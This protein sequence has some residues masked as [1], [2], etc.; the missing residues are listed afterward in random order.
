MLTFPLFKPNQSNTG[1]A[2]SFQ[3]GKTNKGD[4]LF[5]SMVR[6]KSWSAEKRLGSFYSN[7]DEDQSCR[8]KFNEIEMGGL[9]YAIRTYDKFSA[10]HTFNDDKTTISFLPYSKKPKQ[11]ESEGAKAFS[12]TVT[13]NGVKFGLGV[14]MAEAEAMRIFLEL[15]LTQVFWSKE[16][17]FNIQEKEGE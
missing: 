11:G 6:Q 4:T 9:I 7:K 3:L 10:F 16:T 12:L 2:M 13:K 5:L 17:D 1:A 8:V 14:E 15:A